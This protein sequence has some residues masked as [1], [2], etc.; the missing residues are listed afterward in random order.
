MAETLVDQLI[1]EGVFDPT[2]IRAGIAEAQTEIAQIGEAFGTT[3]SR[4]NQQIQVNP[5]ELPRL[6]FQRTLDSVQK[7]TADI[8]ADFT[9]LADELQLELENS[10]GG[11]DLGILGQ[12]QATAAGQA[13]RRTLLQE[14]S[15]I[16][17]LVAEKIIDPEEVGALAAQAR[18]R[19]VEQ[20]RQL[21]DD[22][23]RFR[24]EPPPI[25]IGL[26][27]IVQGLQAEVDELTA[28][29]V[30]DA[31]KMHVALREA[32]FVRAPTIEAAVPDFRAAEAGL[33]EFVAR[34]RAVREQIG[35]EG[36]IDPVA[37]KQQ[38]D[39]LMTEFA[40][41][42][43]RQM[44]I[45]NDIPLRPD[46]DPA[47]VSDELEA[48]SAQTRAL[49][50][51]MADLGKIGGGGI[52][53]SASGS[54][55]AVNDLA[56]ASR[57]L[58]QLQNDERAGTLSTR[59][60][61]ES[62]AGL[63][64]E[65][66]RL[67]ESGLV[68]TKQEM[69]E[70]NRLMDA[71]A[72]RVEEAGIA[73]R[74]LR[75]GSAAMAAELIGANGAAAN[76]ANGLLVFAG[77]SGVAIAAGVSILVLAGFLKA[78]HQEAEIAKEK[79]E[80]LAGSF[81][82]NFD[83]TDTAIEKA[84][85]QLQAV[86]A[87]RKEV[88]TKL[89]NRQNWLDEMNSTE[90]RSHPATEMERIGRSID[91]WTIGLFEAWQINKEIVKTEELTNQEIDARLQKLNAELT[92]EAKRLTFAQDTH[93]AQRQIVS[94]LIEL[95]Q[96]GQRIGPV[97]LGFE[98]TTLRES[99]RVLNDINATTADRLGAL[100]N[101][102]E[103][104]EEQ[105]R[106]FERQ[107]KLL[108]EATQ[109]DVTRLGRQQTREAAF[110]APDFGDPSQ[111]G[112]QIDDTV[113]KLQVEADQLRTNAALARERAAGLTRA[114]QEIKDRL[115]TEANSWDALANTIEDAVLTRQQRV[116]DQREQ[117]LATFQQHLQHLA[118]E[119]DIIEIPVEINSDLVTQQFEQLIVRLEAQKT[120]I[121]A[122]GGEIT[123]VQQAKLDALKDKLE[124][125]FKLPLQLFIQSTDVALGRV[126][127]LVAAG[128]G[129]AR[130]AQQQ[131]GV[132]DTIADRAERIRQLAPLINDLRD[133][134]NN[135]TG[136][137][138]NQLVP[139][140]QIADALQEQLKLAQELADVEP[141]T[142]LEV[143]Q[144]APLQEAAAKYADAKLKL[145]AALAH[146]TPEAV[147]AAS[148][149]VSRLGNDMDKV[150]EDIIDRLQK[151]GVEGVLLKRIADAI[152][153]SFAAAGRELHEMSPD[154]IAT[155]DALQVASKVVGAFSGAARDLGLMD[156]SAQRVAQGL[157]QAAEA[158]AS[159]VSGDFLGG[160]V[161]GVGAIG[162]I[163]GGI[164]GGGADD[165]AREAL[166][167]E[168]DRII[169]DNIRALE[170]NTDALQRQ[171]GTPSGLQN[172]RGEFLAIVDKLAGHFQDVGGL[173]V[174]LQDPEFFDNWVRQFGTSLDELKQVADQAGIELFDSAGNI[175]P[176]AFFELD[177]AI[178]K[179]IEQ[180][181]SFG[182]SLQ[183][184]QDRLDLGARLRGDD[185]GLSDAEQ[186]KA[187]F[188]RQVQALEQLAPGIA[189]MFHDLGDSNEVRQS[190]VE[191]FNQFDTGFFTAHP[192]LFGNLTKDEFL[193]FLNQ[194]ADYLD[195]FNQEVK[196][197]KDQFADFNLPRGFREAALAF[198]HAD[199]G[200]FP[201][202]EVRTPL[203]H[204][205]LEGLGN[206]MI[207][208]RSSIDDLTSTVR[209]T[210][211]QTPD[212]LMNAMER[213]IAAVGGEPAP[214]KPQEPSKTEIHVHVTVPSGGTVG[215]DTRQII[216]DAVVASMRT[217]GLRQTGNTLQVG[218][219]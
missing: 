194:G 202:P 57:R 82:K 217:I 214:E 139:Q 58:K 19:A 32:L 92:V 60:L 46:F 41:T 206:K 28:G 115:N 59:Q 11:A 100:R 216:D 86:R 173:P 165:A 9:I 219:F 218:R 176:E 85:K 99:F 127:G 179:S 29:V 62:V 56:D 66:I 211:E 16:D 12:R 195:S 45:L 33:T 159:F 26:D 163:L 172:L 186:A 108:A 191:L 200:P 128:E 22:V 132:P 42:Y 151:M 183:E 187:I 97:N 129:M 198:E 27:E 210:T 14:L 74:H 118:G 169:Q 8:R 7:A 102:N 36:L 70:F 197:V 142:P 152:K 141:P 64:E 1:I 177:K 109:R 43:R 153:A 126:Q 78:Y 69:T 6:E 104:V 63:R 31:E 105:N 204:N 90:G 125:V 55:A 96:A 161:G 40:E 145:D 112:A 38:L 13:I 140:D 67:K 51:Q 54:R 114:S 10:L 147:R 91:R 4:I 77:G 215:A 76:L 72:P 101:I 189:S 171:T 83:V 130:L 175:I 121:E 199:R 131:T 5:I 207:D 30:R 144:L 68:D 203:D 37:A 182:D 84:E 196:N 24:I 180:M 88:E 181:T 98:A 184:Q 44:E 65:L 3:I 50:E 174:V 48:L 93:D 23:Q 20:F 81:E 106:L 158:A 138:E 149:E 185:L 205:E 213:L 94:D 157:E 209:I 143:A 103:V 135:L 193:K 136:A 95:Q 79:N 73:M 75:L 123:P 156:E 167:A 35:R 170:L 116:F 178:Q 107:G 148:A 61:Q 122:A 124:D 166:Q 190:L 110:I 150:A 117:M 212:D 134:Y 47:K 52:S 34:V 133:R 137:I 160:V 49:G 87:L 39:Q 162:S 25:D 18:Q 119:G 89:S 120:I 188:A 15:G 154:A 53:R 80:E 192:D 21:A 208:V 164:F 168:H 17:L 111:I 155:R 71:T 201:Q 146:G 113:L 2:G